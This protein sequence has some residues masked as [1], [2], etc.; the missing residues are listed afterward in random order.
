MGVCDFVNRYPP[1]YDENPFQIYEKILVGRIAYPKHF[2]PAAKDLVKKLLQP[3][4][5][6]R[7][8]CLKDGADDIK[9]HEFFDNFDFHGLVTGTLQPPVVPDITH[10]GDTRNFDEFPEPEEVQLHQIVDHATS[11]KLFRMF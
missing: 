4:L 2:D 1:Y 9:N 10:D 5:T 6:K 3:D 8:G 7:Y 11:K